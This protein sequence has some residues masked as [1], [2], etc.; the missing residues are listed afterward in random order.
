MFWGGERLKAQLGALITDYD[1][2]RIDRAAYR[3]SVGPEI[4]VSPTGEP[5]DPR[6]K[7]P[8]RSRL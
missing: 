7:V 3:L 1:P 2:K 4:Y 8:R 6:N 5:D